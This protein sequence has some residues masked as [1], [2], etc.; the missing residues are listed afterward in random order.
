MEANVKERLYRLIER[1][2]DEDVH[3]VE[4]YLEYV[5]SSRDPVMYTLMD[6]PEEDEPISAE[7]E[8]E[9]QEGLADIAAG[10]VHTL[11][12]VKQELGL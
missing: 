7:E 8:A 9:V 12:E 4:R 10:R 2:P 5:A 3:G 1:I 11:A 6:A